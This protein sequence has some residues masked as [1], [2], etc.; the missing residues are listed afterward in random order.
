M[1]S[2]PDSYLTASKLCDISSKVSRIKTDICDKLSFRDIS[3]FG[4]VTPKSM[5]DCSPLLKSHIARHLLDVISM[6]EPLSEYSIK[7]LHPGNLDINNI[8]QVVSKCISKECNDVSN[9]N[10]FNIKTV[11]GDI[12]RLN[13]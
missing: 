2:T 12:K 3:D 4:K 6:F 5:A 11:R 9:S 1:V 13:G 10:E 8:N 7:L